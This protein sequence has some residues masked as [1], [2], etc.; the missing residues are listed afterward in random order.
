M[1]GLTMKL[2]GMYVA[3]LFC[4]AI[5]GGFNQNLYQ[6]QASL[7]QQKTQLQAHIRLLR[8]EAALINGPLAVPAWAKGKGMVSASQALNTRTV[9][10]GP[11]PNVTKETGS[12]EVYTLWH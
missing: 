11:G 5:M 7:I 12:V 9:A 8:A 2:L 3:L 4:L 6:R 1:N 10:P